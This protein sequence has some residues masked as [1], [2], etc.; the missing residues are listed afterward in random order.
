MYHLKK[1]LALFFTLSLVHCGGT[2]T[3]GTETGN[4]TDSVALAMGNSVDTLSSALSADSHSLTALA[5]DT[6]SSPEEDE[7]GVSALM[8]CDTD[9][10]FNV[11]IVCSE[12]SHTA[13]I[14][15]DFGT[16]CDASHEVTVT[17]TYYNSWFN[18]GT[19]AC[20]SSSNRPRIFH[21]VQGNGANPVSGSVALSVTD[22]TTSSQVG[23]G[24]ITFTGCDSETVTY[25]GRTLRLPTLD[26]CR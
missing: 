20:V 16:G 22:N 6:D 10:T 14:V 1:Y 12:S 3:G 25:E 4:P 8:S 15:R 9:A 23:A 18:M 5:L 19:S 26:S 2:S 24:T 13:T 21:A 7:T 17:G 11:S